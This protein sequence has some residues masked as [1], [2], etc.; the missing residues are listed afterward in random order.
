MIEN[1]EELFS[2]KEG[3]V[4]EEDL[5]NAWSRFQAQLK[6]Y[7]FRIKSLQKD[8]FQKIICFVNG[9]TKLV[10]KYGCVHG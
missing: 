6:Q 10:L 1:E 2:I 5:D 3:D 8:I 7:R 4:S 9:Q